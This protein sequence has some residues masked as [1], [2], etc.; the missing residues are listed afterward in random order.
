[1]RKTVL[2]ALTGTLLFGATS[3]SA[4]AD[5]RERVS[6]TALTTTDALIAD[7]KAEIEFG[8]EVAA[9]ILGKYP[10]SKDDALLR[11]VSLVGGSVAR[12]SGR[13][14]LAYRFGV[15][16]TDDL[17]AY[18]A[19]GG[20]IFI[21]RGALA[22]MEDEA[23]LAAVLAHEIAHVTQKHIVKELDIK[24]MQKSPE[25]GITHLLGGTGDP[26]RIAFAQ[27]VDKAIDLLFSSGYKRQD[28]FEADRVGTLLA[29]QSGYDPLALQRYLERVSR[30]KGRQSAILTHTHPPFANRL[31]ALRTLSDEEGL[32]AISAQ[33]LKS[34]FVQHT[35]P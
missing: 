8:R 34:R 12:H 4:L 14:E 23:E 32:N 24:G 26:L 29:A 15:L 31:A 27:A 3:T 18:A 5:F 35:R 7:V 28:E 25:A 2:C 11:Y 9:R 1:M 17:N 13:T 21:T 20:Y 22:L 19:P 30:I 16:E 33:N 10:L 6:A